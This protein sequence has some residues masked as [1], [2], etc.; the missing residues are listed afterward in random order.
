MVRRRF[1]VAILAAVFV[2]GLIPAAA[3]AKPLEGVDCDQLE[4]TDMVFFPAAA[5]LLESLGIDNFGQFVSFF[6]RNE[7]MFAVAGAGFSDVSEFFGPRIEFAS[8]TEAVN[9]HAKC[10]LHPLVQWLINGLPPGHQ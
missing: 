10:G 3:Q 1:V 9:T 5:A 4:Q 8:M 7:D 2:M 6:Q